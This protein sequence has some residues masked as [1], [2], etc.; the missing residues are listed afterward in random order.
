MQSTR[1][2]RS[3]F[4]IGVALLGVALLFTGCAR[5]VNPEKPMSKY[6]E[7]PA[8][9]VPTFLKGT[10]FER[11]DLENTDPYPISGYG[12][13][14]LPHGGGD[15][16][17]IPTSVRQYMIK[18]MMKNGFG[19][20]VR[21]TEHMQPDEMLRDPHYTVVQVDAFIPPGARKDSFLDVQ[22]SA[23]EGSATSSL[24]SGILYRA[25]LKVNGANTMAPAYSPTTNA[26]AQ[27]AIFVNPVYALE[28]PTTNSAK[29]SLRYGVVIGG[30]HVMADRPLFLRLRAPQ[31]SMARAIEWRV[32]QRFAHLKQWQHEKFASARDEGVVYL[33]VP[34]SYNGDWE[35]FAGVVTH[36]YMDPSPAFLQVKA[37]QLVEEALKPDAYL[38]DISYC[39]EGIGHLALEHIRPLMT[40]DNA[41][42]AFAAARAAAFIG[43]VTAQNALVSMAQT[44]GHKYQLDAVQILGQLPP[45]P[46]ISQ[47]LRQLLNAEHSLVRLEAYRVLAENKDRSIYSRVI[48]NHL[49]EKFVLDIVPSTGAPLIYASRRGIPRIAIIGSRPTLD[50]PIQFVTM[51]DRLTIAAAQGDKNVTIF[52]R[53]P[54]RPF[55]G[56]PANDEQELRQKVAIRMIS[57][58]DIAE[59]VARLGGESAPGE[60]Q[61]DFSYGDVVAI[62]R[63]LSESQR[64]S[65][66]SNGQRVAA[67]FVLQDIPRVEESIFTAPII[68]DRARPQGDETGPI[69]MNDSSTPAGQMPVVISGQ[70]VDARR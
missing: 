42:V 58:P 36:L 17:A 23:L 9:Q 60:P 31:R 32:E 50:L 3:A 61:F 8:K 66:M 48:K 69:G 46:A 45:S 18:E 10:I 11:V 56:R 40:H 68:P 15:N 24:A 26:R 59:I 47:H 67:A 7:R 51:N 65:A 41:D 62:L 43:D 53:D 4:V 63:A 5:K 38:Q 44:T 37:R 64:F 2:P 16:T 1:N 30:G 54:R 52:Y 14:F 35:R 27:G 19:S 6:P 21:G 34:P 29:A 28:N 25:D 12:L 13:V 33:L 39:W 49:N 70:P 57:R 55:V 20:K 22:V